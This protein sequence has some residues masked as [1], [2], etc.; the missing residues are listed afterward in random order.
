MNYRLPKINDEMI[1]HEY[2]QEHYDNG[3]TGISASLGLPVSDYSEW[4]E[5]IQ[6][7]ASVGNDEWGKTVREKKGICRGHA[8]V[9]PVRL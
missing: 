6:Q 5:K 2:I 9:C 4:V 1:L 3:E 7:N 8:S